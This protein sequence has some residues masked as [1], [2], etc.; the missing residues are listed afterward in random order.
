MHCPSLMEQKFISV[1]DD[2]N[3]GSSSGSPR[4]TNISYLTQQAI[5]AGFTGAEFRQSRKEVRE[6]VQ[7]ELDKQRIRARI[8]AE[9]IARIRFLEEQVRR[10][11]TWERKMPMWNHDGVSGGESR[12]ENRSLDD[13]RGFP[14]SWEVGLGGSVTLPFQRHPLA[15]AMDAAGGLGGGLLEAKPSTEVPNKKIPELVRPVV[16][17]SSSKRKSTTPPTAGAGAGELHSPKLKKSKQE[18]I[19]V[20]CGITTNSERVLNDHLRG[21][22]HRAMEARSGNCRI[23]LVAAAGP[24][25]NN[26]GGSRV[27]RATTTT[28][29][30]SASIL[31]TKQIDD[32]RLNDET[33]GKAS[34]KMQ[35]WCKICN[36]GTCSKKLMH[37]HTK[38]KKHLKKILLK[39]GKEDPPQTQAA[40]SPN[41]TGCSRVNEEAK[42]AEVGWVMEVYREAAEEVEDDVAAASEE[43]E[44]DCVKGGGGGGGEEEDAATAAEVEA[45]T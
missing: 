41:P 35:H 11:L 17:V 21:K 33:N 14:P 45:C 15:V 6:A 9:E 34:P 7:M 42:K 5:Q 32:A 3:E 27:P 12:L 23:G 24:S 8:V 28:T 26:G 19:C 2:D 13:R 44:W 40:P 18:W 4:T 37:A 36:V 25:P 10:E 30:T 31:E 1:G 29:T 16:N 20:H 43:L 38:G 39:Q 22:K